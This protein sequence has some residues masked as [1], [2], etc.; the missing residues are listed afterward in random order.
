M[1]EEK[2]TSAER[3]KNNTID[4][5]NGLVKTF[6]SGIRIKHKVPT[7]VAGRTASDGVGHHQAGQYFNMHPNQIYGQFDRFM[8]F[9]DYSLMEMSPICA[10]AMD[11]YATSVV[12]EDENGRIVIVKSNNKRI[13]QILDSF[14]HDVINL[15]LIHI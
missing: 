4:F 7:A 1:A 14:F 15:S 8:R 9:S 5:L 12:R 6:R 11:V 13:K 2:K 10:S 3:P